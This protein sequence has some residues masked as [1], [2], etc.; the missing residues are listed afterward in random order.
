M[1]NIIMYNM[2]PYRD[3]KTHGIVNRNRMVLETMLVNKDAL[4]IGKIFMVDFLPYSMKRKVRE[5][6]RADLY[7]KQGDTYKSGLR[8]ALRHPQRD[9]FQ[10]S[11]LDDNEIPTLLEMLDFYDNPVV[12]MSYNPFSTNFI[13]LNGISLSVFETVD[14]WMHNPVF[15]NVQSRLHDNYEKIKEQCDLVFTVSAPLLKMFSN[16]KQCVHIPNGVDVTFFEHVI[17]HEVEKMRETFRLP[18]KKI[19]GY[20]GTVQHRFDFDLLEYLAKKNPQYHF[21]IGGPI[22]KT[23]EKEARRLAALDNIQMVGRISYE[24]LPQFIQLFDVGIVPHITDDFTR[25]MNPM[26]IFDYLASGKPVVTTPSSELQEFHGAIYTAK[27]YEDFDKKIGIATDRDMSIDG[28]HF[29]KH[30]S[31][32]HRVAHM[33]QLMHDSIATKKSS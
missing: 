28:P 7:G 29:V 14:N 17:E 13:S 18:D 12:S 3:W 16:S 32:E 31:W 24:K 26:K 5:V 15:K 8:Y 22:M 20:V 21:L 30:H 11:G 33:V 4:G 19:I 9:F 23:S 2:S 10:Y 1:I 27:D 6:L 25:S